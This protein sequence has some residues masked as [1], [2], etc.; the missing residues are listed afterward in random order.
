[1]EMM[2]NKIYTYYF[3]FILFVIKVEKK[4]ILDKGGIF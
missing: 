4:C 1:M 3:C 2:L